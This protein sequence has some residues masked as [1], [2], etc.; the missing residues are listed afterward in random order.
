LPDTER[1]T[2]LQL[3]L[4]QAGNRRSASFKQQHA[5]FEAKRKKKNAKFQA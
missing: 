4:P 2:G 3:A 5:E 1:R